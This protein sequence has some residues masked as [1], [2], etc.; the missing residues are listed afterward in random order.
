MLNLV[1]YDI[2][3]NKA[4]KKIADQLL[5]LGLIR[6]QYSVFIGTVATNRIDELVLFAQQHLAATD[7]LYVI[8]ITREGL[9][10]SCQIGP[11]IE[12]AL[13]TDELLTMVI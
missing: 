10:Q 5:D 6:A 12:T 8:P 13:V 9:Q 2:S 3:S 7:R 4:R 1:I 11:G